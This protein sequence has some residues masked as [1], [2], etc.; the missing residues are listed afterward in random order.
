M[1]DSSR[2]GTPRWEATVDQLQSEAITRLQRGDYDQAAERGHEALVLLE[3][4]EGP[5]SPRVARALTVLS[6][7]QLALK[8]HPRAAAMANRA[9]KIMDRL[10]DRHADRELAVIHLRACAALAAALRVP[11]RYRAA[12]PVHK[13]C[14]ALARETLGQTDPEHAAA[15]S[16]LGTLYRL[17]G[18]LDDAEPLH[19]QAAGILEQVLG[20]D[21]PM[22]SCAR[23]DLAALEGLRRRQALRVC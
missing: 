19:R 23:D 1:S 18:R 15:L 20:P 4:E 21:H 12:E 17:Q 3:R 6:Q 16:S 9:V 13:R 2:D 5:D 10:P 7:I 11:N 22:T 8:H 14:V